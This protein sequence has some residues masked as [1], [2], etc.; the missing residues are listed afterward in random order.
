M[1]TTV[2][3]QHRL[4]LGIAPKY[5]MLP[6]QTHRQWLATEGFVQSQRPPPLHFLVHRYLQK[7]ISLKP[8]DAMLTL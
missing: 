3:H 6:K 8:L 1:R 5:Q 7:N 2:D 4:S